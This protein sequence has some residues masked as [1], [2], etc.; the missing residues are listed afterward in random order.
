MEVQEK[1]C[2]NCRWYNYKG[3]RG[4]PVA[5]CETYSSMHFCTDK[6]CSSWRYDGVSGKEEK[7]V[8]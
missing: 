3:R 6:K 4:L 8:K 7:D 2:G 5:E 1:T